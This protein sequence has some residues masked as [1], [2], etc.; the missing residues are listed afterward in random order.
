MRSLVHIS[1]LHFGC[2]D[3]ALLKPLH[4]S[5]EHVA[6]NL[7]AISGDLTQRARAPQFK[8]AKAF[9]QSLHFPQLVVPGNHD[10]PLYNVVAR[11]FNPLG[12]YRRYITHNLAPL[13]ADF[14]MVVAGINTA[15]SLTIKDGRISDEQIEQTRSML[16]AYSDDIVKIVVTHHPFDLPAGA[17]DQND[18]V[19]RAQ[20]AVQRFAGCGADVFLSGHMHQ[21][22]IGSTALRYG[23][24]GESALI[25]HAGTA[26]SVRQR[27]LLNGFN[28]LRVETRRIVVEHHE[29]DADA[30]RFQP[31][32]AHDFVRTDKGW[33]AAASA[34]EKLPNGQ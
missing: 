22:H 14:E 17:N 12:N 23:D 18:V 20:L 26:T 25:V 16:C 11:F 32:A 5:I 24:H 2:A 21:T 1:D 7:I 30:Q 31:N 13:Y 9:L 34:S 3:D 19:G 8:Q 6:P 27:G 15:R 4:E 10:I 33:V 29:W 28:V